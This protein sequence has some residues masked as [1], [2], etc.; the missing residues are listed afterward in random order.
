M[1]K[2]AIEGKR[3][4]GY[5]FDPNELVIITDKR[6][7]LYDAREALPVERGDVLDVA[8]RGVIVP[9]AVRKVDDENV[10]LA[11]KQRTKTVAVANALGAAQPYTGICKAVHK[12]IKEFAEDEPFVKQL[13]AHMKG[14]P[15]RVPAVARNAGEDKDA[16]LM[17][18]AENARRRGDE[19]VERIRWAQEAH[20]KFGETVE[21]IAQAENVDPKTVARWLK[22]DVSNGR[23]K[24]RRTKAKGPGKVQI[25]KWYEH[26]DID[27]GY[28]T[29]L[30]FVLGETTREEA[31]HYNP[32]LKGIL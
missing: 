4:D 8:I 16:R 15:L 24:P 7:P 3:A 22:A 10:V 18:R 11:G 28:K 27:V 14:R 2:H 19:T 1:G 9:I 5:T 12:A 20:E 29:F 31:L 32:E 30:G 6:H 21:E 26:P 17:M 23:N 25:R 13:V